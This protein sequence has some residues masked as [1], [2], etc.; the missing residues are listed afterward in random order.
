MLYAI[1]HNIRSLH[2]IGSMFRTADGAGVR[3][4]FLTGY[5]GRPPRKEI[6]KTAL[7]AE[8]IVSWEYHKNPVDV[9]CELKER[10]FIIVALEQ[11]KGSVEYRDLIPTFSY[12]EKECFP[13]LVGEG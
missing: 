1:L 11:A 7:G 12:Q 8:K 10:G 9:I 6:T 5:S 3:K 2:N 4:I 13:L